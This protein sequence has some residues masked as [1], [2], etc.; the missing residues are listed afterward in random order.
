[1][2][3]QWSRDKIQD[4]MIKKYKVDKLLLQDK[5]IRGKSKGKKRIGHR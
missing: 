3:I 5:E 4:V 2:K 1:M